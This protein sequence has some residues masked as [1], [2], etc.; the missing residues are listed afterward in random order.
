VTKIW[1][2]TKFNRLNI[3]I[4]IKQSLFYYISVNQR[5]LSSQLQIIF[6]SYHRSV[7][8][9]V[10]MMSLVSDGITSFSCHASGTQ[11]PSYGDCLEVKREYYQNCSVLDCVTKC[12]QSAAHLYEQFL[13]V[14]Q[15]GLSHWDP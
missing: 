7:S 11:H 13:K 9:T 2:F 5:E 12:S 10:L 4:T 1:I 6:N 15:L 3:F 14:Q 8:L